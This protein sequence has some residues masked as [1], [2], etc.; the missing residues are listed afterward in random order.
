MG[1]L[2]DALSLASDSEA[3]GYC[4]VLKNGTAECWG[5]NGGGTG[6]AY[7]ELGSG[8]SAPHSDVP[9]RVKGL[10]GVLSIVS[11]DV[12]YCAVLKGGGAQ[13]WGVNVLLPDDST[14]DGSLGDG[15]TEKQ[16]NVPVKVAGLGA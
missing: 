3:P 16:S 2:G 1:H 15:G 4:A 9:A 7:G 11:D 5:S 14:V 10:V 12:G 6:Y 13:C 8:S